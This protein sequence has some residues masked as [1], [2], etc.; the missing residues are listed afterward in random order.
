MLQLDVSHLI[1]VLPVEEQ[2]W[3]YD[4][5]NLHNCTELCAQ[6]GPLFFSRS[7]VAFLKSLII[8]EQGKLHKHSAL[9]PENDVAGPGGEVLG[10]QFLKAG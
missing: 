5:C 1:F 10:F 4:A 6:K 3:L 2:G 8:S 9:G 7:A